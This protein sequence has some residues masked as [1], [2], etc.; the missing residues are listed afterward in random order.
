MSWGTKWQRLHEYKIW[1][2]HVEH[3]MR[4]NRS[5]PPQRSN[6]VCNG[7]SRWDAGSL[8]HTTAKSWNYVTDVTKISIHYGKTVHDDVDLQ[9]LADVGRLLPRVVINDIDW[10]HQSYSNFQN[11]L[12]FLATALANVWDDWELCLLRATGIWNHGKL[13]LTLI[14]SP[15]QSRKVSAYEH[16]CDGFSAWQ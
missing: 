15:T 6:I 1:R 12:Q 9:I 8:P 7:N 11:S 16:A 14:L 13:Q 5:W 3:S 2:H 10:D 4:I